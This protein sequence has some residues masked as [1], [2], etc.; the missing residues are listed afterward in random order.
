MSVLTELKSRRSKSRRRKLAHKPRRLQ[1]EGLEQKKLMSVDLS[2]GGSG[3]LDVDAE[4]PGTHVEISHGYVLD[5]GHGPSL[6]LGGRPTKMRHKLFVRTGDSNQALTLKTY[7][8]ND[9]KGIRFNGSN[10]DD[11]LRNDTGIG[12]TAF[13][14]G[15]NDTIFG[16][17]G[18]DTIDGGLG[19]DRIYGGEGN[20]I[21]IGGYGNDQL[22]GKL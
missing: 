2:L 12:L 19:I 14:N 6:S 4:S 15:G 20:D 17:S 21:L 7:D 13:G 5:H 16:G 3:V 11:F 10:Y 18:A 1:F 8:F 9:I 22:F